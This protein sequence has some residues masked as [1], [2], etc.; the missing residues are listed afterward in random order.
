MP[1]DPIGHTDVGPKHVD[2]KKAGH[3]DTITTPHVD[4]PPKHTDAA[5]VHTDFRTPHIDV[6]P[7][8]PPE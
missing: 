4:T 6:L 8:R 7:I 1:I 3:T 2:T 5:D